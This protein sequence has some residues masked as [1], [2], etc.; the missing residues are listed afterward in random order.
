MSTN[1]IQLEIENFYGWDKF[2]NMGKNKSILEPPPGQH[3]MVEP[4]RVYLV[5]TINRMNARKTP[6]RLK[7]PQIA[8][9]CGMSEGFIAAFKTNKRCVQDFP[10]DTFFK[11]T[12]GLKMDRTQ[13][14]KGAEDIL[15]PKISQSLNGP[16]RQLFQKFIECLSDADSNQIEILDNIVNTIHRQSDEIDSPQ[17]QEA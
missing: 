8:E 16:Y 3:P 9:M 10:L 13:L 1:F 14:V 4:I 17:K 2:E 12:D 11:L 7:I 15:S 5:E 6:G